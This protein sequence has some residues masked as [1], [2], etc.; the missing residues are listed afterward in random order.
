[1]R[2]FIAVVFVLVQNVYAKCNASTFCTRS[3]GFLRR[4]Y[5]LDS[6]MD[7]KELCKMTFSSSETQ[8]I[9]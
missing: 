3:F 6:N 2:A 8:N 4:K 1:M 9:E 5:S 7:A